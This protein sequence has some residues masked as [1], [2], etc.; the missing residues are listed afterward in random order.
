MKYFM[1]SHS[2]VEMYSELPHGRD[3]PFTSV[4][5]ELLDEAYGTSCQQIQTTD[6]NKRILLHQVGN[7][8]YCVV[9]ERTEEEE[10]SVLCNET[11][12]ALFRQLCLFHD[13][14]CFRIKVSPHQGMSVRRESPAETERMLK[15]S[16]D[17]A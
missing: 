8:H 15:V 1:A 11:P 7:I 3:I 14:L 17:T 13:L 2:N 6:P 10:D 12:A 9:S 4:T 5:Q 16:I